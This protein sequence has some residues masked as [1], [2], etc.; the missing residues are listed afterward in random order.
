MPRPENVGILGR[1]PRDARQRRTKKQ[2]NT[3]STT[4]SA[5]NS[6][7]R[8]DAFSQA[9]PCSGMALM[10]GWYAVRKESCREEETMGSEGHDRLDASASRTVHQE[11]LHDRADA[12]VAE[13]LTQ[14]RRIRHADADIFHQSSRPRA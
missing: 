4:K 3:L 13:S 2:C 10:K 11:C 12:R 5:V 6:L 1:S 8:N 7:R 9:H 14:R